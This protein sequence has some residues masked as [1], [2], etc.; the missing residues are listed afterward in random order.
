MADDSTLSFS[1]ITAKLAELTAFLTNVVTNEYVPLPKQLIS[2]EMTLSY[3]KTQK[4]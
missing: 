3:A 2:E 1:N 4:K